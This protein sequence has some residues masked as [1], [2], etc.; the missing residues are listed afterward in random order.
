MN[1]K[2]YGTVAYN[3]L[4][5]NEHYAGIS[6]MF[7]GAS[8]FSLQA[9]AIADFQGRGVIGIPT[10]IYNSI[11]DCDLMFYLM[12]AIVTGCKSSDFSSFNKNH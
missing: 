5:F 11:E 10:A 3:F 6:S 7:S 4:T 9:T 8:L 1:Q 2:R 12:Y